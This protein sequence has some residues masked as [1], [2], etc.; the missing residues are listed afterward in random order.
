MIE[1]KNWYGD[2]AHWVDPGERAHD[3]DKTLIPLEIITNKH[4]LNL[5]CFYPRIELALAGLAA[6]WHSIDFSEEVIRRCKTFETPAMFN[7]MDMRSLQF[8]DN[9]FDTVLDLSSGDHMSFGDYYIVLEEVNR[10]L[11]K[12]GHF[13]VTYANYDHFDDY[14]YDYY[15]EWGYERRTPSGVMI[16]TL[17]SF[18]FKIL[19]EDNTG[20]RSGFLCQ[21]L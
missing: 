14:S 15:G 12:D 1:V 13:I 20:K 21:K 17:E 11:H 4:I 7:V 9:S 5:G 2:P 16:C 6:S 8:L 3:F 19:K 10:V 18:G